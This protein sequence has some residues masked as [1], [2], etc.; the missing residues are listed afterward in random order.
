[1][2]NQEIEI[3]NLKTTASRCH[4]LENR[5]VLLTSEIERL[6]L[7]L[8]NKHNEVEEVIFNNFNNLII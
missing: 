5:I 6:N 3:S 8:R 1:M 7:A 2:D 4:D